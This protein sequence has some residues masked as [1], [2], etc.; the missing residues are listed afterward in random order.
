VTV[1]LTIDHGPTKSVYFS[2]P[3]GIEL[4]IYCEVPEFDW[5]RNG[6]VLVPMDIIEGQAAGAPLS[7]EQARTI[8]IPLSS[9]VRSAKHSFNLRVAYKP[10]S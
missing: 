10:Y 6:M 4:E 8:T 7:G 3:D 5:R 1:N 9:D 2:D